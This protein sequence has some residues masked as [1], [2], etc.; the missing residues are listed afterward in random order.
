MSLLSSDRTD[1]I[2]HSILDSRR[3]VRCCWLVTEDEDQYEKGKGTAEKILDV[4][5]C[6]VSTCCGGVGFIHFYVGVRPLN[7]NDDFFGQVTQ[8]VKAEAGR[9]NQEAAKRFERMSAREKREWAD[10]WQARNRS[11]IKSQLDQAFQSTVWEWSTDEWNE[12]YCA[13]CDLALQVLTTDWQGELYDRLL[14]DILRHETQVAQQ[15]V[16]LDA[17]AQDLLA[18]VQQHEPTLTEMDRQRN[19][20]FARLQSTSDAYYGFVQM[21]GQIRQAADAT[22][23]VFQRRPRR[24]PSSVKKEVMSRDRERCIV[25]RGQDKIEIDHILP[26]RVGGWHA[27]ENLR[28][29]CDTCHYIRDYVER[30]LGIDWY[31]A[32]VLTVKEAVEIDAPV[33]GF[34]PKLVFDDDIESTILGDVYFWSPWRAFRWLACC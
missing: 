34:V 32:R 33:L 2:V 1:G 13:G 12:R 3:R 15:Y 8:A 20:D 27:P 24:I 26:F 22:L 29:L 17:C 5:N 16:I 18:L 6:L 10:T 28:L 21:T 4:Q 11:R 25:C 9:L 7:D 23:A 30:D 19:Q 31:K 14:Q